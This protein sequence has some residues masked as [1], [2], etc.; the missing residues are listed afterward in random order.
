MTTDRRTC[1]SEEMATT[2]LETKKVRALVPARRALQAARDCGGRRV[3]LLEVVDALQHGNVVH[4]EETARP[5]IAPQRDDPRCGGS[6][7]GNISEN[8]G[9]L[10]CDCDPVTC[11]PSLRSLL[12]EV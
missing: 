3:G 5:R 2:K 1:L 12:L 11:D 6:A 10:H 4:S 7:L 8:S 9:A